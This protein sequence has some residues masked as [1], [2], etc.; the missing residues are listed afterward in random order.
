MNTQIREINSVAIKL[1]MD[2]GKTR[3]E[4]VSMIIQFRAWILNDF[5]SFMHTFKNDPYL[6]KAML[7]LYL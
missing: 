4:A 2:E 5:L 3:A 1:L 7:E 6:V